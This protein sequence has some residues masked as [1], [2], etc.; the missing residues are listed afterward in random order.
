[1][2]DHNACQTG[3]IATM[4]DEWYFHAD[5]HVKA[6]LADYSN[7]LLDRFAAHSADARNGEGV[8]VTD[9]MVSRF[10][11]WKLPQDFY[12]DCY[13]AFD[14]EKASMPNASWPTGTNL[15]HAGQARAMLEH[16]L[17]APAAPAPNT[18]P[19]CKGMNCG[20]TDGVNHSPECQA[21]HAATI[22]GGRF[23][24]GYMTDALIEHDAGVYGHYNCEMGQWVFEESRLL[25]FARSV[26]AA[27]APTVEAPY[28]FKRYEA[29]D[30]AGRQASED[31]RKL[32]K[33]L[34]ETSAPAP[35]PAAQAE[36]IDLLR[37]C[38]DEAVKLGQQVD[39]ID[40][41]LA[42]NGRQQSATPADAMLAR[43]RELERVSQPGSGETVDEREAFEKVFPMPRACIRCDR[44]GV[45]LS[46]A[47][48]KEARKFLSDVMTAAGL[49]SHGKQC[50]A[51]GDRLGNACMRF[52]AVLSRTLSTREKFEAWISASGRSHLLERD[53]THDW[54]KDLTITAM[55]SAWQA[56]AL[57]SH[58]DET[59]QTAKMDTVRLDWLQTFTNGFYNLD[60][61]SSTRLNGFNG[62]K[63]LRDAIDS[64]MLAE[65][66]DQS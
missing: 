52:N 24:K 28:P 15:L 38:R 43:I 63:S 35:A 36:F 54:Y 31:M 4:I 13:V 39:V 53:D 66:K 5:E 7:V 16:V 60:R 42:A 26:A 58:D 56:N 55:W 17:A 48:I 29:L 61:I 21:E 30:E 10:L 23:V 18:Y 14:R 59:E 33:Y 19:P 2:T 50:K 3:L 25:E 44:Q 32:E 45:A 6:K 64:A 20:C 65:I 22:A 49:V 34:E 62:N 47:E 8:A 1:M 37:R 12:P 9:D 46:D 41:M 51:L 40:A 11:G 57:V 27:P